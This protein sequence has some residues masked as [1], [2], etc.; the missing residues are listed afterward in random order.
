MTRADHA[1]EAARVARIRRYAQRAADAAYTEAWLVLDAIPST[2]GDT[3]GR[4]AAMVAR[5]V[6]SRLCA[7]AGVTP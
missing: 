4:A 1:S 5:E 6:Y 2:S 3:C 7:D